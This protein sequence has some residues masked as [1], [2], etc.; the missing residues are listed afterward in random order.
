MIVA[1]T[2][3]TGFIGSHLTAE[4]AARGHEVRGITR[5]GRAIDRQ[6]T[7]A[8]IVWI[9][10]DYED[11][12]SLGRALNEV[13]IVF[14][15]AGATRAPSSAELEAANVTVTRRVL[16]VVKQQRREPL[17]FVFISSQAAGGPAS[18][19]QSP[20]RE[21]DEPRPIEAYGQTKLAAERVVQN[22]AVSWTVIRPASVYGPGDRDFLQLFRLARRGVAFHPA[23]R[24]HWISIVHVRDLVQGMIGAATSDA[25][26]AGTY[27]VANDE[28]VQW[29]D[30]FRLG[31]SAANRRLA[32]DVELPH[33]LVAIGARAGD[34]FARLTG[35]TSLLTTEKLALSR[36]AFWVCSSERAKADF[37]FRASTPLDA[38]FS[39]TYNWYAEH[40]WL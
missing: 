38:G 32:I 13:D 18:S 28:P 9:G 8:P 40:G 31:A 11:S 7:G 30:L 19:L 23:N 5:A 26:S 22:E 24:E 4:L 1:V 2:G 39:E 10:V 37:G 6:L 15:A 36:P 12:N 20:S 34:L 14:H 21:H 25:A 35:I 17:R 16:D 29:A 33:T 27:Y 3:A